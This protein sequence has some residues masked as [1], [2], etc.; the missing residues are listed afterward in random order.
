MGVVI[1][2]TTSRTWSQ[3][4]TLRATQSPSSNG[5]SWPACLCSRSGAPQARLMAC[6]QR[7]STSESPWLH[8]SSIG[9]SGLAR[10]AR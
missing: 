8:S 4:T 7:Q 6:E 9:G 3:S 2:P 5:R 1:W 10:L